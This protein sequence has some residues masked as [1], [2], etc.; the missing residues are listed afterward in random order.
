[1]CH[2]LLIGR[3]LHILWISCQMRI[4]DVPIESNISLT[5]LRD[6]KFWR[7][8]CLTKLG[9]RTEGPYTIELVDVNHNLTILLHEEITER[10]NICRDL[11]YCWPFHIP[12]WR[13]F[14][15]WIVFEVFTFYLWSFSPPQ[16]WVSCRWSLLD[17]VSVC[18][19]M[20][21]QVLPWRGRVS[22]PW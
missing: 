18:S 2:W 10:I 1:M 21:E 22:C 5:R 4:Y 9:V 19:S 16:I 7:S 13:H 14:L 20:A 6:N 11:S 17:L 8:A 12:L 15:A 3:P